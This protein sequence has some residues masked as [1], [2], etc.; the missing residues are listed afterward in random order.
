VIFRAKIQLEIILT[1]I[2]AGYKDKIK[3]IFCISSPLSKKYTKTPLR[4]A[5]GSRE[6]AK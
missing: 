1:L 6:G 5:N 3:A 4:C 2:I